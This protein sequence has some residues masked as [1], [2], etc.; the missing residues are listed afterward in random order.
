VLLVPAAMT[1]VTPAFRKIVCAID[2]SSRSSTMITN[3]SRFAEKGGEL[4]FL[5]VLRDWRSSFRRAAVPQGLS[6]R[7]LAARQQLHSL[8]GTQDSRSEALVSVGS[9]PVDDEILRVASERKADLI[10][11]GATRHAGLCRRF[12]G[13]TALRVSRRSS[14]PVLVLPAIHVKRALSSLDEAVLG[15]AA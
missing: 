1:P 4:A 11:L 9:K 12:L 8:V 2:L 7:T 15:W 3:V 6:A 13:S 5:H 10:V 14:V